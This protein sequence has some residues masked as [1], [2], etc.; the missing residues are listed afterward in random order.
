[1]T[2]CYEVACQF[3][4]TTLENFLQSRMHEIISFR[5]DNFQS[6]FFLNGLLHISPADAIWQILSELN[7]FQERKMPRFS[8]SL[9][10]KGFERHP[11]DSVIPLRKV[12]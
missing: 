12:K 4:N 5:I 2:P 8:T 6:W 11:C 1:V 10:R 9:I 3:H 7:N